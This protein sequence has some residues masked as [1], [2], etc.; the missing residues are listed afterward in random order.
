MVREAFEKRYEK[1]TEA[2][3]KGKLPVSPK[4]R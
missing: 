3:S 2:V 1:I 4:A